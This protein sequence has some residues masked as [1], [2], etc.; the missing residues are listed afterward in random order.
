MTLGGA[1]RPASQCPC[2]PEGGR[3][4]RRRP[5]AGIG[6]G[7]RAGARGRWAGRGP[8]RRRAPLL[9]RLPPGLA[10]PG[11]GIE[12]RGWS[13]TQGASA[14]RVAALQV[15]PWSRG[16]SCFR[17][18]TPRGAARPP[19]AFAPPAVA[20]AGRGAGDQRRDDRRRP[21]NTLAGGR[22]VGLLPRSATS[23]STSSTP[24]RPPPRGPLPVACATATASGC[25]RRSASP[26]GLAG[27][28]PRPFRHVAAGG[29]ERVSRLCRACRAGASAS[30]ASSGYWCTSSSSPNGAAALVGIDARIPSGRRVQR[31]LRRPHGQLRSRRRRSIVLVP[32]VTPCPRGRPRP[33]LGAERA[34]WARRS[35][36][37]R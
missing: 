15:A 1:T 12:A 32:S 16:T 6:H 29:A 30:S 17:A 27:R 8:Q 28:R 7:Q 3:A 23:P 34:G 20:D 14:G 25:A 33:A 36:V 31:P 37:P 9:A 22:R 13:S 18:E 11:L 26:F 24:A 2:K 10:R 21:R 4:G 5:C 19:A 35:F